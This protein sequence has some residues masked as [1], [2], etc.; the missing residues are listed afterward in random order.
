MPRYEYE[1]NKDVNLE[2]YESY[3]LTSIWPFVT[4]F[5]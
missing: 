3:R 4:R 2:H 5:I 1:Y